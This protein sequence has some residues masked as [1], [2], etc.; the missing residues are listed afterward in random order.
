[1]RYGADITPRIANTFSQLEI[2]FERYSPEPDVGTFEL[3]GDGPDGNY[4]GCAHCVA[5]A[6]IAPEYAYFADRRTLLTEANPYMRR[7]KA[8][9]QDLRLVEVN[10]SLETRASTPVEGGKCIEVE[11]LEID[12]IFPREGWTCPKEKFAD[13]ERCDCECG[14]GDPDCDV[15]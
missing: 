10:V 13:G 6:G 4:G 15:F 7:L 2:L 5:I 11:D 14:S 8:K 3:G 9:S 1:V 12:A